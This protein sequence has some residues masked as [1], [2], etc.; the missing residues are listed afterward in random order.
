MPQASAKACANVVLQRHHKVPESA[1]TQRC[2]N[3]AAQR[4][5]E[6][7]RLLRSSVGQSHQLGHVD[8]CGVRGLTMDIS[9]R[10]KSFEVGPCF[11]HRPVRL[12]NVPCD[13]TLVADAIEPDAHNRGC[14]GRINS[15][16]SPSP[17]ACCKPVCNCSRSAR[18]CASGCTGTRLKSSSAP[19]PLEA[20]SRSKS[21]DSPSLMSMAA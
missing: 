12:T 17:S 21:S 6:C 14:H 9:A 3:S 5:S 16:S 11:V 10:R 7:F 2:G 15:K 19:T 1:M 13:A 20:H 8:S 18:V 4:C